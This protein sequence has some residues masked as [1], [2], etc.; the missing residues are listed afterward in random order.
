[1]AVAS[2]GRPRRTTAPA[3]APRQRSRAVR[4]TGPAPPRSASRVSWRRSLLLRGLRP[5][6]EEPRALGMAGGGE[7]QR[8][9]QAR[10]GPRHVERERALSGQGQ[11]ADRARLELPRL[12]CVGGERDRARARSGS[13]RRGRRPGPRPARRPVRSSQAAAARCRA[14]RADA[15]DLPVADVPDQQV[16]E[17]VLGLALPSS[18][19][20][21][22]APAP[23]GPARAGPSSTSRGSRSPMS[24]SAP[25]QKTLPITAASWSRLLRSG[26]S[27]SRRAAISAC[28]ESGT[29][30]DAPR[31]AG[32]GRRAGA[33]TPRRTRG[34]RPPAR[35]GPAASPPAAPRARAATRS[36]AR[37]PRR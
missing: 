7:R 6:F 11:V 33:R 34:C 23:C 25:A 36:A 32:R 4:G 1:M 27:V 24:A 20:A 12:L 21:R 35:A 29:W 5:A 17:A 9:G 10:L 14:A 30:L 2:S 18:S 22:G 31:R 13:G 16:P 3:R 37:S 8:L 19:C 26:D 15:G 28:T